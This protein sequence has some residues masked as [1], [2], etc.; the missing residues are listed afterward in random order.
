MA[1]KKPAISQAVAEVSAV[2]EA[3]KQA[4]DQMEEALELVELAERQKSADEHEIDSLRRTL[5]QLQRGRNQ[6][7]RGDENREPKPEEPY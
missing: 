1:S 6:P 5:R 7:R 3:L 2:V 4:L